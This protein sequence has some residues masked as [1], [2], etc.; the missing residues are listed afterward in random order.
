MNIFNVEKA[1]N[2]I[3]TYIRDWFS[4]N[5]NGCN[6]IIGM[7]GGK[8]STIAA[9]LLV[10]ALG[11]E[12][13]IGVAMPDKGQGI[14]D[15]DKICEWLGIKYI[16]FPIDKITT[17]FEYQA[18]HS[19]NCNVN[20]GSDYFTT[21]SR[22]NIPPRVRMTTLYAIGQTNNGRVINTCNLSENYIGYSTRYG[23]DAGDVSP[24]SFFTVGELLQIGDYLGIPYEW[25]HKTPDDGLPH[26]CPDEEKLGFSYEEVD[27][28]IRN[29]VSPIGYCHGN[30]NEETKLCK[31]ER[32]HKMN[33][34][35]T[36][37]MD[38]FKP[39]IEDYYV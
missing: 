21:Q 23:D 33:E 30:P 32:M 37:Y 35:K 5:G 39:N 38:C 24:L 9:K 19:L 26:S 3:V 6:A 31:I 34:F 11:S 36:R 13:V 4:I 14:N 29:N 2:D 10:E 27:N 28:L 17:A 25:V 8:D 22:Q 18:S 7:S 12:R 15:A 20:C 1:T 16:C